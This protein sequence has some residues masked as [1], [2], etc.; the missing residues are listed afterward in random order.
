MSGAREIRKC[1]DCG[2]EG[3]DS[4]TTE[5]P[6]CESTNTEIVNDEQANAA[7]SEVAS[8]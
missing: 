8:G 3:T 1:N 6:F 5:C 7:N 4:G 2:E